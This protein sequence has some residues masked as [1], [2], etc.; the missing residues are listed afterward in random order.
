LASTPA[1]SPSPTRSCS[2]GF[3]SVVRNDRILYI[4]TQRNGFDCCVSVAIV[5][6]RFGSRFWPGESAV[7]KRL[8]LFE[9]PTPQPWLTVVGVVSNIV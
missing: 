5:N 8:R 4:D 1:S 7:G 2:K 6:Q 9:G 3:P